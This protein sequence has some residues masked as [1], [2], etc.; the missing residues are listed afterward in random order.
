M[1]YGTCTVKAAAG[2]LGFDP[3]VPFSLHTK[4]QGQPEGALLMFPLKP[5]GF[6]SFGNPCDL[7]LCSKSKLIW[8]IPETS[9]INIQAHF[10]TDMR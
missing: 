9:Y 7:T 8:F 5:A 1:L 4:S 3:T 6:F 10:S 2:E